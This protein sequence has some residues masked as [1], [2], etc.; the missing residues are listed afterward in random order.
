MLRPSSP[1]LRFSAGEVGDAPLAGVMER[2]LEVAPARL[3]C[4]LEHL[5]ER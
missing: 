5:L 1:A 2:E 3:G 4:L